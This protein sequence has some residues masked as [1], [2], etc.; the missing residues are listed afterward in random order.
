MEDFEKK[1]FPEPGTSEAVKEEI[2]QLEEERDILLAK[3]K[4]T[5]E[6]IRDLLLELQEKEVGRNDLPLRF[7]EEVQEMPRGVET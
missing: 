6:K 4:K 7:W 2:K 5:I 1:T 3:Q